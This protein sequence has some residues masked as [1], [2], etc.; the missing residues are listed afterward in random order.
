[1]AETTHEHDAQTASHDGRF[2]SYFDDEVSTSAVVWTTVWLAIVCALGMAI[3][4]VM[5]GYYAD[6]AE[7]AKTPPSPVAEANEARLPIGPLLQR[8]PEGELEALRH[9]MGERLHGYGW[10]DE[11]AGVVH[12]P[13]DQA[14]DLLV[15]RMA[16][17][18]VEDAGS[19]PVTG[20]GQEA[21]E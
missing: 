2:G 6:R 10:V 19:A 15:E 9:E 1:M 21:S 14:M 5:Q 17:A 20:E 3:T 12:I 18:P 4:W 13:I 8:H 7:A 11:H 16:A